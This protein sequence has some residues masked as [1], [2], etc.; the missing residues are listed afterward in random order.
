MYNFEHVEVVC[1]TKKPNDDQLKLLQFFNKEGL[2]SVTPGGKWLIDTE[3]NYTTLIFKPAAG[4]TAEDLLA[5]VKDIIDINFFHTF[6]I[7]TESVNESV[8]ATTIDSINDY[9]KNVR[10][11]KLFSKSKFFT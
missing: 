7:T 10:L 11:I 4:E 8:D 1:P 2:K 5:K 3:Y 9:V 6:K